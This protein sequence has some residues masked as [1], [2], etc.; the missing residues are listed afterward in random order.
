VERPDE[1]K[2]DW[3]ASFPVHRSRYSILSSEQINTQ[4][5]H[6]LLN[7]VRP[8]FPSPQPP[9]ICFR[10][11]RQ[12]PCWAESLL[13]LCEHSAHLSQKREFAE[14]PSCA[15]CPPEWSTAPFDP[16]RSQPTRHRSG[17]A[18]TSGALPD[19][20]Q[21]AVVLVTSQGRLI[22]EVRGSP[23]ERRREFGCLP[24]GSLTY[25]AHPLGA[26]WKPP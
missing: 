25:A 13:L 8:L 20:A 11:Q 15:T 14:G 9:P 4:T 21:G 6:G 23:P 17:R 18:L 22:M 12:V 5:H 1:K 16:L 7:L 10:P 3:C 24:F 26:L 19:A 2:R